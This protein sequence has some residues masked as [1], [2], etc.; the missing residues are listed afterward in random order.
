MAVKLTLRRLA[1]RTLILGL[2]DGRRTESDPPQRTAL[3]PPSRNWRCRAGR[4][5][6][7]PASML[8]VGT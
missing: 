1:V 3:F 8:G 4:A 7:T 2:R 6:W 5:R